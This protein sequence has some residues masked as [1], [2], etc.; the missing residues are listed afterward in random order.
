MRM[1]KGVFAE[2]AAVAACSKRL[3]VAVLD[4]ERIKIPAVPCAPV[5]LK[6]EC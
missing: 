6:L 3:G 2:D 4:M 5:D 1:A